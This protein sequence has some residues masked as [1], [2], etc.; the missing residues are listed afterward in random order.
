MDE[1]KEVVMNA[2]EDLGAEVTEVTELPPVVESSTGWGTILGAG[3]AAVGLIF[4]GT[5]ISQKVYDKHCEKKG[6]AT[7]E[8]EKFYQFWR[9]KAK[10]VKDTKVQ[11]GV[12]HEIQPDEESEEED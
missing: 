3:A 12:I 1:Q 4:G 5:K 6:I 2:M 7:P 11:E 10:K 9:K 8:R